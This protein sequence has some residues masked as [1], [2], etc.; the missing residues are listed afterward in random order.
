MSSLVSQSNTRSF[1]VSHGTSTI[2]IKIKILLVYVPVQK[3]PESHRASNSHK[4]KIGLGQ[5]RKQATE[6]VCRF[7]SC[8]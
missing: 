3:L 6:H 1:H 2:S 7:S 8:H 4:K 5:K